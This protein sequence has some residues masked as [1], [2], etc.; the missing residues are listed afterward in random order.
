MVMT[1]PT[2]DELYAETDRKYHLQY[3]TGPRVIDPDDGSHDPHEAAWLQIRD[4]V[5]YYWTDSTF[6]RFFPTAGQLD[7]G[8]TVLIEY[9]NDIK[10]QI[11]GKPGRWS[12]DSPPDAKPLT[13]EEVTRHEDKGGFL[14]R[15][16]DFLNEDQAKAI[17]WP[18]GMPSTARIEMTASILAFVHLDLDALSQMPHEIAVMFSEAGIVTAE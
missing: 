7:V 6:K 15:F 4:E 9:W 2:R 18:N 11:S 14:V 5:L 13:V 12:W 8:D 3:P 10:D 1:L 16:S 17:L